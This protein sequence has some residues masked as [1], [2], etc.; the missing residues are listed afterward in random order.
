[1]NELLRDS[2]SSEGILSHQSPTC[3][4]DFFCKPFMLRRRDGLQ[5]MGKHGNSMTSRQN[6]ALMCDCVTAKS[7]PAYNAPSILRKK[8]GEPFGNDFAM[9]S[10]LT[11][12]ND[13][14]ATLFGLCQIAFDIQKSWIVFGLLQKSR[15][16]RIEN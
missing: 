15:I 11:R 14:N 5:S 16:V 7:K 4:E 3:I 8:L 2:T 12:S 10:R 13:R 6:S 9:L 1:M